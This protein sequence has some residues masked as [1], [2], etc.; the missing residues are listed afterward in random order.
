MSGGTPPRIARKLLSMFLP[1]DVRDGII[2]DLDEVY[3]TNQIHDGQAVSR[4]WYWKQAIAISTR[5]LGETVRE[6]HPTKLM[7][8]MSLDLK[9]G[10][11]MLFKYPMLTLVGGVAIM[12]TATIGIAGAEF[13]KD[14]LAP[15]IP[16][17]EGDRIVRISFT[18]VNGGDGRGATLYDLTTW[19][20]KS[21]ALEDLS[22]YTQFERGIVT[23]DG[24]TDAVMGARVTASVFELTRVAPLQGRYL[25]AADEQPGAPAVA[26]IGYETWQT[27][28]DGSADAIG[29]TLQIG[30]VPTT[31][32]G[33]M[34]EGYRFPVNHNLWV[35][36]TMEAVASSQAD[37]SPNTAIIARLAEDESIESAKTELGGLT[38]QAA[39][40][41][42]DVYEDVAPEIQVYGALLG[43]GLASFAATSGVQ[44]VLMFF[45]MIAGINVATLVFAR[46]VTREGEIAVRMSMGATRARIVFQLFVEALVLVSGATLVAGLIAGWSLAKLTSL[47]FRVQ[48]AGLAPFWWDDKLSASTIGFAALLTVVAAAMVG[49]LPGLKATRGD[50]RSRLSQLVSGGANQLRFG[51]GWTVIIVL[52]LALTVAFLPVAVQQG[53]MAFGSEPQSALGGLEGTF[54]P[55]T[56][57]SDEILT[58]QLGRDAVVPVKDDKEWV[59]F[60]IESKQLFDE[61][62]R[63]V[64]ADPAVEQ[65]AFASGLSA[66][67]HVVAPVEFI[68]DGSAPPTTGYSIRVLLVDQTY[69]PMMGADVVAGRA[70][71]SADYAEGTR[72]VIV[73]Q[74]FVD[75]VLMGANPIGGQI[76]FP[77]REGESSVLE[78][79]PAG[80]I[81]EIVGV[82]KN[83]EI[84]EFGPGAHPVVYAPLA[85]A[86]VS[87]RAVGLVGMP[88]P[89]AVQV[90]VKLRPEAGSVAA[91]LYGIVGAVNPSLRLDDLSTVTEA[92]GPVHT[93]SRLAGWIFMAVAGV[94]LMLS[95]AGIYALMSFTVSQRR[96]EIAIRSAVGAN[97][98]RVVG[99]IFKRALLQLGLGIGLGCVVAVPVLWDSIKT[100]GPGTL[101]MVAGILGA[102]GVVACLIPVRRALRVQPA[103]A[104]KTA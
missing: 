29:Q 99:A 41:Y 3:R 7:T 51:G 36:M 79:P 8:T 45:L 93:S 27:L 60:L 34:P 55:S 76:R 91:R 66:M 18:G 48:Q 31:V 77:E 20:E 102:A 95:V 59:S 100:N 68:G 13:M 87:P 42:P 71:E 26:V 17:D 80:E 39:A 12:V 92:W 1:S 56:F 47:F 46:T 88:Q 58:A 65:V 103:E 97:P 23:P 10:F 82:V 16:L 96:R 14:L 19:R 21:H 5:F 11:R 69:L 35:P 33:V 28:L 94:I 90:F 22:G 25:T 30:G 15:N 4:A 86:P 89:P 73:N 75:D 64:E 52:Q 2:G 43:S 78:V 50:V 6:L 98:R 84:D 74:E 49:V 40:A 70:F 81:F 24:R 53:G 9:L 57:P 67:N 104:V 37:E 83:P 63:R 44:T 61:V 85:W 32:V 101:L 54:A 62:R 38:A 72:A